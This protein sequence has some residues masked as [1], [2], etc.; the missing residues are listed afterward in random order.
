MKKNKTKIIII[1]IMVISINIT[2]LTIERKKAISIKNRIEYTLEKEIAYKERN[3]TY[4]AILVI[5]KIN[6]KSGIY[7]TTDKRNNI[8]DNIM[9]HYSSIYPDKDN[10]N[11][12]FIAHSGSGSKAFFKNLNKLDN[13]SLVE[14]YYHHTKYIYKLADNYTIEKNGTASIKRDKHKKTITLITC[15]SKDKTKQ[16]VYIGYII[17]EVKY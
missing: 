11:I 13:D 1:L 2:N 15:D 17:D 3:D 6:L 8:E 14:F 7:K 4:D 9:I 10:S 12:I 16:I 5:P